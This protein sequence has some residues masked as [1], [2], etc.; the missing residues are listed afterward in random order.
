LF[1]DDTE[2]AF[3]EWSFL[4]NHA[5]VLMCVAGDPD[6]RLRDVAAMVN[7]T[8]RNAY[9]LVTDL[10]EAG[11]V[12]KKRE[13]RRNRYRVLADQP[14][15]EPNAQQRTVGQLLDLLVGPSQR[16]RPS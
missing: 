14:S 13:G 4:T 3:A 9:Q 15:G 7:I 5:R 1:D 2:S 12:V 10:I 16:D 11:Y 6:I 8:E